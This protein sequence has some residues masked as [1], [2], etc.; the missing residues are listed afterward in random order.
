MCDDKTIFVKKKSLYWKTFIEINVPIFQVP[1][2][3]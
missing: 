1:L 2:G 3:I